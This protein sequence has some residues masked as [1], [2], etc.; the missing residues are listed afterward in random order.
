VFAVP[1]SQTDSS[2]YGLFVDQLKELHAFEDGV[3]E[4][5]PHELD[6]DPTSPVLNGLRRT[7]KITSG[8][9]ATRDLARRGDIAFGIGSIEDLVREVLR[10]REVDERLGPSA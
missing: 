10:R 7:F 4:L 3:I 6:Q 8:R 9:A 1:R 5:E 2:S